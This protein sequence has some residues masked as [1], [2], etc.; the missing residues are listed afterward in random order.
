MGEVRT[1]K[2]LERVIGII[3]YACHCVRGVEVVLGPLQ[4]ILKVFKDG[5]ISEE[6]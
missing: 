5:N 2:D 4:E 6:W 1:I 3:S